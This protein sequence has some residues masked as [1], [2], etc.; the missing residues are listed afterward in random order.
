MT[1]AGN[2]TGQ[3]NTYT[4]VTN[5]ISGTLSLAKPAD[6]AF[7]SASVGQ[8]ILLIIGNGSGA[9]VTQARRLR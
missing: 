5:L 6:N 8:G 3:N 4:G 1:Y 9:A 2:T 7:S